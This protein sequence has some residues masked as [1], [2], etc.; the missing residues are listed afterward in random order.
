MYYKININQP[1]FFM[2]FTVLNFGNLS[3]NNHESYTHP[4]R[5]D[6][7]QRPSYSNEGL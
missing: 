3:A 6:T 5:E 4:I 1:V 2:R 7:T